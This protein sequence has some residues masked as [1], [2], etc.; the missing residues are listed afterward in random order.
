MTTVEF[1]YTTGAVTG[2]QT[3][4]VNTVDSAILTALLTALGFVAV[5]A[6]NVLVVLCLETIAL[7]AGVV[8]ITVAEGFV[9]V[10]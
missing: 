1:L 4:D 2:S 3:P 10:F 7:F 9:R 6:W 5:L 8:P